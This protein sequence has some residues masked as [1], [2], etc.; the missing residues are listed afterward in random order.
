MTPERW[1]QV[2]EI[3]QAALDLGPG[4]RGRYVSEACAHDTD[5]KR[6][7]EK[8]L[9]Q[10]ESAGDLLEDP[11]YGETEMNALESFV[12]EDGGS[13]ARPAPRLVSNRTRNW[14]RGHGRGL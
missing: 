2:E 9:S 14:S 5:L 10:H 11:L 13:D 3:F 12:D 6:D 7:V 4:E 8:L 1:R